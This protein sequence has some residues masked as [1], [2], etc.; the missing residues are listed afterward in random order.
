MSVH[1]FVYSFP[2]PEGCS[3]KVDDHVQGKKNCLMANS[4]GAE[5]GGSRATVGRST[6]ESFTNATQEAKNEWN[7]P[8]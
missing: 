5:A 7:E 2:V 3:C 4:S 6:R 1:A 8:S